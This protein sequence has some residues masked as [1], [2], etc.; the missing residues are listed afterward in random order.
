M[1][2]G[3]LTMRCAL[4]R[5]YSAKS[6]I[7]LLAALTYFAVNSAAARADDKADILALYVKLQTAQKQQSAEQTLRLL[8]P[9]FHHETREGNSVSAKDF[10]QLIE[11]Q[12]NT[13]KI[14]KKMVIK[15]TH[16]DLHG[17]SAKV[18]NSF[19]WTIEYS[20]P[21]TVPD[22]PGLKHSLSSVG[23]VTNDLRKTAQ[24]WKFVTLQTVSGKMTLD[25]KKLN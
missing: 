23:S 12:K 22:K 7:L 3:S 5:S 2:G 13:G 6:P 19:D 14:V 9:D 21:S 15:V 17:K 4:P 24:G 16:I 11:N 18:T 20:D 25:G 1:P 8:S 10:V